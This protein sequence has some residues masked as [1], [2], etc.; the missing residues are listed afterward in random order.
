[1]RVAARG[2]QLSGNAGALLLREV[3]DAIGVTA[4]ISARGCEFA[5]GQVTRPS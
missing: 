3:D 4:Q 2:E 1:V 5:F